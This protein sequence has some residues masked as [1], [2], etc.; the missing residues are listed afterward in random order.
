[1]YFKEI[2]INDFRALKNQT[3]SLGKY[4][5]VLSGFNGT[6]KSTLL[7]LLGNSSELKASEGRPINSPQ[8]SADFK[9]L[10]NGSPTHD[11]TGSDKFEIF[12]YNDDGTL[13]ESR[14]Y[15][16]T[17]QNDKKKAKKR[18]RLIPYQ[19]NPVTKRKVN[20]AK[21]KYPVLYLGLSRL[22]PLGE[23]P[24]SEYSKKNITFA[25]D[26]EKNWYESNHS[27]ILSLYDENILNYEDV[28]IPNISSRHKMGIVTDKYDEKANSAGQDNLGQILLSI[29]SFKRLRQQNRFTDGG[30]LLID[31]VDSA[32]H[33]VAQL[34]L[35]ELL[36]Q[37]A[38]EL[39]IQVVVSTHSLT[40]LERICP[41]AQLDEN[42][43]IKVVYF[44]NSNR[45]LVIKENIPFIDIKNNLLIQVSGCQQYKIK[46]YC[47]DN[48]ARWFIKHLIPELIPQLD[49]KEV[50]FSCTQLIDLLNA[51]PEYFSKNIVVFDGDVRNSQLKNITPV[52][53]RNPTYIVLPSTNQENTPKE[54][55]LNP[56]LELY[57][58]L[59]SLD[60]SHPYWTHNNTAF[61]YRYLREVGPDSSEYTQ[62]KKRDRTK[63]WFNNHIQYFEETCVMD[64]W[65]KDHSE[66]VE[67]FINNFKEIIN[68]ISRKL[69]I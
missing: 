31:E 19:I 52:L 63:K 41:Q 17:W 69:M 4:L 27:K 32:L 18:F 46:L 38:K 68:K 9:D 22:Y 55:L 60:A 40:I 61:S 33:P 34:R 7:G 62:E 54:E 8:F 30:L 64:Y 21:F 26:E 2:K 6:G 65:I 35:I 66:K 56:E 45:N 67:T 3:I 51:D 39:K 42:Q 24:D 25:S 43:N 12:V 44:D 10:F 29:L 23:I 16:I 11:T 58:Y 47:E 14:K 36:T 53:R 57:N 1:M 49:F 59:I 5:T 13:S 15:R 37:S 48:E 20:D 28:S 50:S